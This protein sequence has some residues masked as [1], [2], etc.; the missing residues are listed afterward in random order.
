MCAISCI[1]HEISHSVYL[2]D[3]GGHKRG[4]KLGK[5]QQGAK[6]AAPASKKGTTKKTGGEENGTSEVD[7]GTEHTSK[8]RYRV[9]RELKHQAKNGDLWICAT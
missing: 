2:C 5:A 3:G 8:I 7:C 9:R 6:K 4:P 1:T